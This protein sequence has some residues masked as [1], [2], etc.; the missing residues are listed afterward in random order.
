MERS[1][2]AAD[3]QR[4][5]ANYLDDLGALAQVVHELVDLGLGRGEL[6][7]EAVGRWREYAATGPH[8]IAAHRVD[9]LRFDAQ[10]EHGELALDV[11][12]ARQILDRHHVDELVQLVDY[13]Q[14]D[15]IRALGDQ[16]YA[17]HR[18]V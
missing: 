14:D 7:H 5:R 11:F 16:G 1:G 18:G 9:Q 3:R 2:A 17:R 12:A 10:L 13:L 4:A 6:D 15:S 8:D